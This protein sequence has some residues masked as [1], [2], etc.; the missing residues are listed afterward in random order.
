[1]KLTRFNNRKRFPPCGPGNHPCCYTIIEPICLQVVHAKLNAI[2]R[3]E[4]SL[5]NEI[6]VGT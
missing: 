2:D 3:G 1:M 4:N 6:G 5:D